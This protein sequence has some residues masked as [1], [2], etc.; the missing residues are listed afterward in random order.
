MFKPIKFLVHYRMCCDTY[1]VVR[2]Y[3]F[4][5]WQKGVDPV[6]ELSDKS[7]HKEKMNDIYVI[8]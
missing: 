3:C 6:K 2:E 5:F 7:L 8:H 1:K 4:A